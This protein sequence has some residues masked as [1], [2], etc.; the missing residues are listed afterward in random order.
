M[1]QPRRPRFKFSGRRLDQS[2]PSVPIAVSPAAANKLVIHTQPSATATA[3]QA[4]LTQPVIYEEDQFG[5]VEDDNITALAV[6]LTSGTGALQGST[7]V[8]LK[9]GIATF[10]DLAYDIAE[11]ISLRF[12]A[13]G[14]S[15]NADSQNRR[16]PGGAQQAGDPNPTVGDGDRRSALRHPAGHL[17]RRPVRQRRARRQLHGRHGIARQRPRA[18]ARNNHGH[19]LGRRGQV[20]EPRRR[21]GRSDR[22]QVHG[23]KRDV[24]GNISHPGGTDPAAKPDA[25]GAWCNRR[26]DAQDQ[27]EKGGLQWIQDPVQHPDESDSGHLEPPTT[28]WSQ[29]SKAPRRSP[30][31]S[32]RRM[33][34]R[35]TRSPS[36]STARTR[37]RR[38][39]SSRSWPR[40]RT[41]SA[42]R[43]AS[44]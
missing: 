44:S 40:H 3:G 20:H 31:A 39:V 38:A 28:S 12:T 29:P 4:F 41:A 7:S 33:I 35:P 8:T 16:Q 21:Y 27:K 37:L 24:P 9:N 18:A 15:V 17:R 6:S 32:A 25:N 30:S 14:L 22:A 19:R 2:L 42:A 10:D 26:H 5:N 36:R 1:T 43:P 34:H 11:S 23:W 13:G